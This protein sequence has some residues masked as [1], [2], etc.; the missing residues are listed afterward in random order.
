MRLWWWLLRWC[1]AVTAVVRAAVRERAI[2]AAPLMACE[3]GYKRDRHG[4]CRLELRMESARH[5]ENAEEN[6]L[7]WQTLRGPRVTSCVT[8]DSE[9]LGLLAWRRQ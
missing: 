7:F 4:R 3:P 9:L 6:I 1:V 5:E 2:A 8:E